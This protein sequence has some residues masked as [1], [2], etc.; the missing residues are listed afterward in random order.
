MQGF[1]FGVALAAMLAGISPAGA[2]VMPLEQAAKMFGAREGSFA[3]DLSP[4]GDKVVYLSADGGSRT[5]VKLLDLASLKE[6][7]IIASDGQHE[8]LQS[9]EFATESWIVCHYGG[10]A[11]YRNLVITFGRLAAID[12]DK[13]QIKPLGVRANEDRDTAIRQNDGGI[14][15][16][17]PEGS[18]GSVLMARNHVPQQAAVGEASGETAGGL[19]V[20][21]IDLASMRAST[22]EAP[23]LD[24][25]QYMTD[26]Q[27]SVRLVGLEQFAHGGDQLAGQTKFRFRL[28]GSNSWRD[29]GEF[30]SR[31]DRGMWPL[32]IDKSID[33]LYY[34][35]KHDGR[36]ALYAMKLDG[37]NQSTLVAQNDRV[38]ISDVLR[39]SRGQPVIGYRYSDERPR[40]EYFD[41]TFRELAPALRRALPNT[42]IIE[43][44]G[45]SRDATKVLVHDSGDTSPGTYYVLDRAS[46]Q[47]PAILLDRP[48]LDEKTL[49]PVRSANYRAADGTTIPAYLTMPTGGAQTKLPAV[50]MPHGGPSSRDQW[51][52]DWLAQFLASRGYVVIQPNYRGSAGFGDEFLG[53]NAFRDWRKAISD[54]HDS[55][56]YLITEGIADPKRIAI[57]GWSYGGY[58][59]LQ[60]AVTDP[61]RYK[62]VIAIAPV[63]DLSALRRDAEGFTNEDLTKDFIGKDDNL[64]S[65]SPLHHASAIKAP[66]LLIHSDLDANVRVAHSQRMEAALR[67]AGTPVEFLHYA[68]L[69]HQLDDSDTRTEMLTRIGLMLERTIGH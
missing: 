9:C 23:R 65:G 44:V 45:S 34:L 50:V 7:R 47:M 63:T 66:V 16:F 59:A 28:A 4:L 58:A 69:D 68:V 60:S 8:R 26:G 20:E 32:A 25:A 13:N 40:V 2:Q 18:A 33:S 31:E 48:E 62:A 35:Q 49:S 61:D 39:V 3:A 41:P 42:P 38:D 22:V 51:G 56:E 54:I 55:G 27:G 12:L 6:R 64:K 17:P 67:K 36:D 46:R 30:D 52:F 21:R 29:L 43:F 11:P 37:S 5:V 19:G 14:L 10:T 1:K 15:D 57:L 24:A 53:E